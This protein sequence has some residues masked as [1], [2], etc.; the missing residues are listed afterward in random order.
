MELG[1]TPIPQ[2]HWMAHRF[3]CS[4]VNML[5]LHFLKRVGHLLLFEEVRELT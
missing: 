4:F 3:F 1:S 5:I 2:V